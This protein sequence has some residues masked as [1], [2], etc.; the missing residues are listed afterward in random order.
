M[1][2]EIISTTPVSASI[3]PQF[4]TSSTSFFWSRQISLRILRSFGTIRCTGT[5]RIAMTVRSTWVTSRLIWWAMPS[6]ISSSPL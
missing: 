3:S 1:A 6:L 5:M 4:T 2:S